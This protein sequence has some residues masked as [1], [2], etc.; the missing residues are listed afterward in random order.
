MGE[1]RSYG[2]VGPDPG[3]H[4][5]SSAVIQ[6]PG[7]QQLLGLSPRRPALR[8]DSYL[9]LFPLPLLCV[10]VKVTVKTWPKPARQRQEAERD[11][12]LSIEGESPTLTPGLWL[13]AWE[14]HELTCR[15]VGT[16]LVSPSKCQ[17]KSSEE[18]CLRKSDGQPC[19][20]TL[21]DQVSGHLGS[22]PGPAT[23]QPGDSVQ[24]TWSLWTTVSSSVG[25]MVCF[26]SQVHLSLSPTPRP[27]LS[28]CPVFP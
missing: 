5:R 18:R 2:P 27:V 4:A 20:K 28:S 25:V 8:V 12:G 17:V 24:D 9:C 1:V 14:R 6:G 19:H 10:R 11:E 23:A 15:H 3:G 7:P 22:G 13:A 21:L 16:T 26:R